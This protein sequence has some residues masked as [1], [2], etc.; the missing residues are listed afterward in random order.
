M[1]GIGLP[2]LLVILFIVLIIFGANRLPEIGAGLG[3]GIR[4]FKKAFKEDKAID[5]TPEK[6]LEEKTEERSNNQVKVIDYYYHT[7]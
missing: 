5:V 1:F 6:E 7:V 4:N 2:E 3:Q